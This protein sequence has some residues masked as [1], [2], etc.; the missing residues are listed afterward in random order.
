MKEIKT[1]IVLFIAV[2]IAA[3]SGPV[4]AQGTFDFTQK[5]EAISPPDHEFIQP[6]WS[7]DGSR[8]A[9]AGKNYR[10]I[11][12]MRADGSEVSHISDGIAAGFKFAWS[13][14]SKEIVCREISY[15]K[16]RRVHVITIYNIQTKSHREVARSRSAIMGLPKW[17]SDMRYI[18]FQT[19]KG[20]QQAPSEKSPIFT[21]RGGTFFNEKSDFVFLDSTLAVAER[22]TPTSGTYLNAVLS[23][24]HK[25]IAFELLGGDLYVVNT[26]GTNLH[27]LGPG[28]RPC[29][30]PDSQWL[31]YMI[32]KDDGHAFLG[33]DIYIAKSDGSEKTNVTASTY[34]LE[35]NPNWSPDGT[36]LV[37][38]E[39]KSG[40]IFSLKIK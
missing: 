16:R 1:F 5:P 37:Y 8:I 19:F 18:L 39:K 33:S 11:W 38:D 27:D 15:E 28:E 13:P 14:D 7:P 40:S 31:C 9:M 22:L 3:F 20:L 34:Q 2:F 32:T 12:L 23:P 30:S 6:V 4:Q 21:K 36:T 24:D 35:M 25:K 10:G 29:W 26:D 17:S